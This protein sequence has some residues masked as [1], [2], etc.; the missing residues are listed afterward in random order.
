V[1]GK[2]IG[3]VTK[4]PENVVQIF[5]RISSLYNDG[6]ITS[7]IE[8]LLRQDFSRTIDVEVDVEPSSSSPQGAV[9]Q[10][11]AVAMGPSPV[12]LSR[13]LS[14]VMDKF[15]TTLDVIA[16]QKS[17]IESQHDDIRKLK[18]AFVLLARSQKKLRCLPEGS[19]GSDESAKI[20]ELERENAELKARMA[21][22]ENLIEKNFA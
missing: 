19:S 17:T 3:R 13:S 8:D 11:A 10:E 1:P 6:K 21:R 20:A 5:E 4:Y 9:H 18:T 14:D 7:E 12:E 15:G 16:D 2:K 22:L